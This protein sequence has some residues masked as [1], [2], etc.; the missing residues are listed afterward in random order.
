MSPIRIINP[1]FLRYMPIACII[2]LLLVLLLCIP[3]SGLVNNTNDTTKE[4]TLVV[5]ASDYE[6]QGIALMGERNWS[7]VITVTNEGLAFYPYNPELLC[8]QA[9]AMR[10]TGHYQEAVDLVS[11]AIPNDTRPIRYANR[12]YALLA[13]GKNQDAIND[14]DSA[15]ALSPSYTTAYV[16]K[17]SALRN[18][19][20][21]SAADTMID[22]ALTVEP[23][24]AY[25]LHLKGGILAGMG[26]CTGAIDAYRH[27]ITI[28]PDYDQPWPGVS[29]A[30]VDLEKTEINCTVSG[31][32][33][34]PTK[35]ALPCEMF[36]VSGMSVFILMSRR[37]G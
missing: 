1:V 5:N 17:D 29:N 2:L 26:N 18:M 36:I 21:L 10:K 28:D 9:Y 13:M 3:V 12:G 37:K 30:T 7:G 25:Y 34:P 11:L 14:A 24:N 15:L 33:T 20:N 31:I 23:D 19:G 4:V 35:A 6:N 32:Q 27:S 22:K 16:L 8:L